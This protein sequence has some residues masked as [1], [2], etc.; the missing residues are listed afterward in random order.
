MRLSLPNFISRLINGSGCDCDEN[1]PEQIIP[2][3][4]Q[5]TDAEVD[6]LVSRFDAASWNATADADK[7]A[8]KAATV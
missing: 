1:A 7:E 5:F 4:L 2:D 8:E 3:H 6:Q